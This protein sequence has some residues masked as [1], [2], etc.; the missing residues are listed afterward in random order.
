M[1]LMVNVGRRVPRSWFRRQGSR[2]KGLIS[3]QEHIW[4]IIKQSLN[5]A[6][7]KANAS[8]TLDF[9]MTHDKEIEDMNYEIEWLKII[10]RGTEAQEKEE[11]EE[12]LGMYSPLG[13]VLKKDM[14]KDDKMTVHFKTKILNS[15]KVQEA[16]KEGYG[17]ADKSNI[18]NKLLEM[19]ILTHIEWEKDFQ[20]R[21]ERF[22]PDF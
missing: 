22:K 12:A 10:I 11:Y 3:F 8:G 13:K 21:E 1:T 2:V 20:T 18:S 7:K 6:K 5:M 9:V 4:Q 17:A 15:N 14:P 16:Y 19:G